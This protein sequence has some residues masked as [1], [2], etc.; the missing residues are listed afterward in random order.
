MAAS[1]VYNTLALL[2]GLGEAVEVSPA[3]PEGRF[4]PHI[5]DHCHLICLKCKKIVDAPC[6]EA[7]DWNRSAEAAASQGFEVV[8]QVH[9][10][11]GLCA[12][13]RA[14]EERQRAVEGEQGAR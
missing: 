11:Y 3:T 10:V 7:I 14:E 6:S 4:D 9:E 12:E 8:R 13:C 1:T 2:V 5:G